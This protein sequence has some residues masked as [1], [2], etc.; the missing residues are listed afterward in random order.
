MQQLSGLPSLTPRL[1]ALYHTLHGHYGHEPHWWPIFG[2]DRHWEIIIGALL[3]QQ[4]KW[5]RVEATIIRL[6]D[7]QL[8]HP[9]ALATTTP[10]LLSPLLAGIAYPRQKAPKLIQLAQH[11]SHCAAGDTTRWLAQ[12]TQP[13]RQ[14]LLGLAGVGPET[15]DVI[16]L[17][18]GHHPVFVVDGY[19]RR[20]FARLDLIPNCATL[21]YETLRATIEAALPADLDLSAYRHLGDSRTM[22]FWDYHALINEHCI[23][24]CLAS[25]P[26][27]ETGSAP[28]RPF[29]QPE[30]C[31]GHCPPCSGCPLRPVCL[32][33]NH[34]STASVIED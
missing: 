26:H 27:C 5:E 16:L 33:Y 14:E 12:P 7:H 11:L 9:A 24:H 34:R 31:A 13:L 20:L 32:A 19:L 1:M 6:L 15:A 2:P 25:R 18:A 10:E 3:V 8:Y 22:L 29:A 21:P 23:H 17:Y 28:R 30:K 4:S